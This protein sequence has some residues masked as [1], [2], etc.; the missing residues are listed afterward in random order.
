MVTI[1]YIRYR[2]PVERV[3]EFED[4]Y[5][6]AAVHLAAAPQCHDIELTRCEEEP[7]SYVVRLTW[8]SV[9][10]HLEGSRRPA[11]PAVLRGGP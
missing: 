9:R 8:T 5:R 6:S 4:A 7:E 1:E 10:D 11:L 2:V 3:A